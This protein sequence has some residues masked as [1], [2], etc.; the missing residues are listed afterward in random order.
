LKSCDAK[1]RK[2][3]HDFVATSFKGKSHGIVNQILEDSWLK[4]VKQ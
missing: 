2:S 4:I 3:L 1:C